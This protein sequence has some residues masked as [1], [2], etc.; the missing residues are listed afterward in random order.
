MVLKALSIAA[1]GMNAQQVNLE[2][3]ANNIANVNT[4][5]FKRASAE[6]SDLMYAPDRL[7]AVPTAGTTE[8]VPEGS[9][10][11][12]GVQTSAVR[13]IFGQG[14]FQE[15]KHQFDMM[16]AGR[17]YFQVQKPTGEIFY[18]RDGTFTPNADGQLVTQHGEMLIPTITLNQQDILKVTINDTGAVYVST[19]ADPSPQAPAFQIQLASFTNEAGLEPM[20]DNLFRE[21]SS[22]GNPTIGDPNSLGFG[23]IKQ[24]YLEASNVDSVREITQLI[25]AQRAYEMNSKVVQAADE[26][27][28]IVSKNLR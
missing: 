6:F 18:T 27:S 11:G 20:G 26:M 7:S 24:G 28:G 23:S 19:K 3:I 16:I 13:R 15:T 14:S 2:V 4:T 1:T 9:Y 25:A 12:F 21:T 5:G 17:G 8:A 10:V 22:S